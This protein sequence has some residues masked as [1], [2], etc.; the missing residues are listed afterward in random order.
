[1]TLK[2]ESDTKVVSL[3][4]ENITCILSGLQNYKDYKV[5]AGFVEIRK[6]KFVVVRLLASALPDLVS[7]QY[8]TVTLL[9]FYEV[10]WWLLD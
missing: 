5:R 9:A 4:T 7:L 8:E 3:P 10:F 1:V 6:R 2:E